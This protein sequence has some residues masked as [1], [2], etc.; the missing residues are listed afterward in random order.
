MS[1]WNDLSRDRLIKEYRKY[2]CL[3]SNKDEDIKNA[4]KRRECLTLITTE[5]NTYEKSFTHEEVRTQFKNLRDMYRRKRKKLQSQMETNA[6]VDEPGWVYFQR[7]K[8]LDDSTDFS[9]PTDSAHLPPPKKKSKTT[10]GRPN[11]DASLPTPLEENNSNSPTSI[12]P[13]PNPQLK[14]PPPERD[15]PMKADAELVKRE[16]V[17]EDES[18]EDSRRDGTDETVQKR[19][20]KTEDGGGEGAEAWDGCVR[21]DGSVNFSS[22]L[23]PR[24]GVAEICSQTPLNPLTISIAHPTSSSTSV[25]QQRRVEPEEEDGEEFT[26]FGRFVA[27]T[28]RKITAH[29][30]IDA[31]DARKEISDVLYFYQKRSLSK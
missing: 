9:L 17:V 8:F 16:V 30:P 6:S 1:Q 11:D 7:L 28:L 5:L 23:L 10:A 3:W 20:D 24:G 31:L 4:E 15:G 25:V 13:S 2:P 22:A 18:E 29:S 26:C 12:F 21:E 27:M 19:P 14:T